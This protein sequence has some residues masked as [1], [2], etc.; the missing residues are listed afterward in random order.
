MVNVRVRPWV[1][2]SLLVLGGCTLIAA[3]F[4]RWYTGVAIEGAYFNRSVGAPA[5][6]GVFNGG[7]R[8]AWDAF[9]AFD[10]V[11]AVFAV[12]AV[13]AGLGGLGLLAASVARSACIVVAV[14]GIGVGAW[15]LE[16]VFD[17][18]VLSGLGPGA[19][20]GFTAIVISVL[21]AWLSLRSGPAR[22]PG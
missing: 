21:G 6:A 11:L 16:R 5:Y 20:I 8:S 7:G 12:L 18:P 9:S 2:P 4:L 14:G 19:V 13:V 22:D 17:R 10:V 15:T 3:M 1:M